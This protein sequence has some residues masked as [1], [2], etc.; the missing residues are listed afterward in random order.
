[1]D[2]RR[3]LSQTEVLVSANFMSILF[4]RGLGAIRSIMV[5][6]SLSQTA[7]RFDTERMHKNLKE[8]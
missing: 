8:N 3:R 2:D 5:K 4:A 6:V 1:M 7:Q